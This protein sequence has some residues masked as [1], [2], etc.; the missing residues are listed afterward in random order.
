LRI[1]LGTTLVVVLPLAFLALTHLT[2]NIEPY[3]WGAAVGGLIGLQQL[4]VSVLQVQHQ[5]KRVGAGAA[6]I[7]VLRLVG[8]VVL[9]A[10]GI[11]SVGHAIGVFVLAAA[12][13]AA[14]TATLLPKARFIGVHRVPPRA[15]VSLITFGGWLV[16]G[17]LLEAAFQRLDVFSLSLVSTARE[18]GLYS[19]ALTVLLP[20][21]FISLAVNTLTYPRMMRSA[22]QHNLEEL[23][24]EFRFSTAM[25]GLLGLPFL[26]LIAAQYPDMSAAIFGDRYSASYAAV[27]QLLPYAGLFVIHY[28]CGAVFMASRRPALMAGIP[29]LALL[30]ALVGVLLLVPRWH[31]TGAAG[32]MDAAA[33][34]S[35]IFSWVAVRRLLSVWP[36]FV[37]LAGLLMAAMLAQLP[38]FLVH[39]HST[40]IEL[41]VRSLISVSIY[42]LLCWL[43]A[44]PLVRSLVR[45]LRR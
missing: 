8:I 44:K 22:A 37:T 18:V 17:G 16:A 33:L 11:L 14:A 42:G 9:T 19:S 32:S 34:V 41:A 40:A 27:L 43:L 28:N 13:A 15:Y 35:L 7:G 38:P 36:P 10:A 24:H 3:L 2:S 20:I 30:T 25:L 1:R 23:Q 31:V 5:F 12:V 21:F 39:I 26:T 45:D 4:L 29:A 6:A